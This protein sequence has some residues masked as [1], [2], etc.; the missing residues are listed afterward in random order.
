MEAS[1]DWS[2]CKTSGSEVEEDWMRCE[3]DMLMRLTKSEGGRRITSLFSG[4]AEGRRLGWWKRAS[5]PASWD[6]GTCI[7][8][9]S[10]SARSRSQCAC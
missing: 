1:I 5:G 6:S 4:V 8:V 10:K 7:I 3:I 2:A 9:G